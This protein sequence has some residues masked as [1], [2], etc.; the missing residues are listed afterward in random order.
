MTL[1]KLFITL[2]SKP[3][4]KHSPLCLPYIS[5]KRTVTAMNNP[6]F[7]PDLQCYLTRIFIRYISWW[8]K[9]FSLYTDN[10]STIEPP[11]QLMQSRSSKPFQPGMVAFKIWTIGSTIT[12]RII[13]G[14]LRHAVTCF[15]SSTFPWKKRRNS[16]FSSRNFL[17]FGGYWLCIP[18][19]EGV[20]HAVA[21]ALKAQQVSMMSAIMAI[22]IWSSVNIPSNLEI[23]GL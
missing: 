9:F 11:I 2:L 8:S 3:F 14:R 17:T 1:Y 18:A 12:C 19:H 5:W 13:C 10:Y 6:V 20:F 15:L 23:P 22:A 16:L 4:G 21:F 7:L